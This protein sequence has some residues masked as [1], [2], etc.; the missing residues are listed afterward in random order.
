MVMSSEGIPSLRVTPLP[1]PTSQP[2]GR[3][4]FHC[5]PKILKHVSGLSPSQ[6]WEEG[7]TQ[8]RQAVLSPGP[9][10]LLGC[11]VARAVAF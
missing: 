8:G 4:S 7:G 6:I 1:F 9:A 3:S 2:F 5:K 10:A 11:S